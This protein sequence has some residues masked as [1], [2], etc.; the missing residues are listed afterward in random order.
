MVI[1]SI[2]LW[3]M[4]LLAREDL[5][6]LCKSKLEKEDIAGKMLSKIVTYLKASFQGVS[7]G[8]EDLYVSILL[9]S[10]YDSH[11]KPAQMNPDL[12]ECGTGIDECGT[13]RAREVKVGT[14]VQDFLNLGAR[15]HRGSIGSQRGWQRLFLRL[16][17]GYP[18]NSLRRERVSC[19][20]G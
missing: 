8:S 12:D 19:P 15:T 5:T 13:G 7:F 14:Q 10:V 6:N 16:T 20:G 3:M 1:S 2:S 11:H 9:L 17:R 18:R 4:R